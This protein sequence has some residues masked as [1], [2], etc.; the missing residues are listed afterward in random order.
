MSP[1]GCRELAAEKNLDPDLCKLISKGK[2]R[3]VAALKTVSNQVALLHSGATV[4]NVACSCR[5]PNSC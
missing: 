3:A 1:G 5:R 4:K 2:S